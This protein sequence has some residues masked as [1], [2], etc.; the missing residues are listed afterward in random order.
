MKLKEA[1][2]KKRFVVTSEVQMPIDEEPEKLVKHLELV[3]GRV[4]GIT[5]PELEIEGIVG[6]SIR[7]CELLKRNRF[8]SIYQTSTRD[9]SRP[10]LQKDLLLAHETGI[11]NILVFTEDYRI[12]GDSLQ[13]MMFFHVDSGKLSSV[14]KHM[15]EGRTVD[16]KELPFKAEF[17]M[18]T[19]VESGWGK[20]VPDLEKKEMEEMARIGT[21]YF[22][23]T[24]VFDVG[25]FDKYMRQVSTFGIPVI[26][27]VG[28]A[29]NLNL[30]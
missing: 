29:L 7:A 8:E 3:R 15:R 11:E 20:H 22:L 26:A 6:D 24:P 18:G 28:R 14:L 17:V 12:T 25:L 4:D 19:G 5:V 23:S 13:E 10:Q 1:L 27:E 21:G 9:K 30:A 2:E 16:G